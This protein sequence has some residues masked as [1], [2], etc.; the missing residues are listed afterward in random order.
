MF[1][2]L[3]TRC[4]A[5]GVLPDG[6]AF[7]VIDRNETAALKGTARQPI[8]ASDP[9]RLT[10]YDQTVVRVA[11]APLRVRRRLMRSPTFVSS[12]LSSQLLFI[13]TRCRRD[14]SGK[15]ALHT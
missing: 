2:P 7:I 1:R 3:L 11:L 15:S 9:S 12:S 13:S 10:L 8:T 5:L 4:I 6:P 14:A